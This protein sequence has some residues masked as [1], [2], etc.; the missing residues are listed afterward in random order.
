MLTM[1]A[2]KKNGGVKDYA[3]NLQSLLK[4]KCSEIIS[5][6]KTTILKNNNIFLHYSGYGFEKRGIPFWLINK[7]KIDNLKINTLGIFFHELYAF[8][9]VTSSAFWLSPIQRH[10]ARRLAERSDF[11]IT[12][13]E[14][15]AQW[16]R[17]FAGDKPH[18]VLPVFSNVGE[19][20][21]YSPERLSKIVI[22]GSAALRSE[23]YRVTGKSLFSWA[24]E[25]Q[26]EVHDIGPII[27]DSALSK[28]LK[29]S[30]VIQHGR[31]ESDEVSKILSDAMFG[32]LTY[33]VDY[34]AKSSVLGAYCAHGVCPI[35]ISKKNESI[36]GLIAGT[37]YLAG[38]PEKNILKNISENI[39][40]SAWTWYQ[41]HRIMMHVKILNQL[42]KE[43]ST[44]C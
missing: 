9:K 44:T 38:I 28:F 20:S 11:W 39:G 42:L 18:A 40:S 17:R 37:N 6:T 19:M 32:I 36:D 1:Y 35:L 2:P 25:Q 34:A 29:I 24:R 30:G 33:P 31:I 12:N 27:T 10:I 43:K 22:F 8:G 5:I 23:T 3:I 21:I 15:S 16:L 7:I 13:R 14:G 26:L 41:P 4:P